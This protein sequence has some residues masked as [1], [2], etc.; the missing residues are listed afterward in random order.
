MK[1]DRLSKEER[2][3][4]LKELGYDKED[5]KY[6]WRDCIN[7]RIPIIME[8]Y[9]NG[10]ASWKDLPEDII[11]KLPNLLN[12]YYKQSVDIE[13][14][15]SIIPK[16]YIDI[17]PGYPNNKQINR[18]IL[19]SN[20]KCHEQLT[21]EEQMYQKITSGEKLKEK[22]LKSLVFEANQ[23]DEIEGEDHRW[24]RDVETIINLC[25]HY[26]SISWQRAL[27]EMQEHE[28][29]EQPVEV[30]PVEKVITVKEWVTADKFKI[31]DK[32][33]EEDEEYELG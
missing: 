25:G 15:S 1:T 33:T 29:W 19:K 16:I 17:Q 11:R 13:K 23:I 5:M 9:D 3:A 26:F 2:K 22:E 18:D 30:Y 6:F 27:T 14:S 31:T 20:S 24:V 28:F 8:Y 32:T 7:E 12:D 10:C 4:L 21:F